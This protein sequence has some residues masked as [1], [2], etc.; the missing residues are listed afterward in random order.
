VHV[1]VETGLQKLIARAYDFGLTR[2]T[3]VVLIGVVVEVA[4][5]N[6]YRDR[7]IYSDM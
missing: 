1:A 6:K 4:V 3:R 5:A 2:I 7:N